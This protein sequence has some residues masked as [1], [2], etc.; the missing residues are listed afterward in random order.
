MISQTSITE[1]NDKSDKAEDAAVSE[2]EIKR[3]EIENVLLTNTELNDC[4]SIANNMSEIEDYGEVI[5]NVLTNKELNDYDY[6]VNDISEI[7]DNE[8]IENVLLIY[9]ELNDCQ[10]IV[11][12]LLMTTVTYQ[13]R[14]KKVKMS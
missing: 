5:D 6:T 2:N 12:I 14:E 8:E 4:Q 3:E 11:S 9:N 1:Y 7:E 10:Y 13:I